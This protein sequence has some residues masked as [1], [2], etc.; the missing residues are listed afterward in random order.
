VCNLRIGR[1]GALRQ[2]AAC[3]EKQCTGKQCS[4]CS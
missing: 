3:G 2:G 4:K 1:P